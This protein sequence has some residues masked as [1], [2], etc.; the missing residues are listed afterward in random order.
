MDKKIQLD[1]FTLFKADPANAKHWKVIRK[2]NSDPVALSNNLVFMNSQ[3]QF[4]RDSLL[5]SRYIVY[6]GKHPSGTVSIGDSDEDHNVYL[7]CSL[8]KHARGKGYG[9]Q[10]L[11][12]L[13]H[14]LF[15]NELTIYSLSLFIPKANDFSIRAAKRSHFCFWGFQK[16]FTNRS[17]TWD[18]LTFRKTRNYEEVVDTIQQRQKTIGTK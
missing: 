17:G 8:L 18:Y 1:H 11:D 16:D 2:M 7:D 9:T 14:Y 15:V 4:E 5:H 6:Q 13:T 3:E 12:E 10:L